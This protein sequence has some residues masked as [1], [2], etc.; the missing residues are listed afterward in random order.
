MKLIVGL[1]NP[2]AEYD[3][4]PHNVGFAVIDNIAKVAGAKFSRK[5][6]SQALWVQCKFAGVDVVL[7]KPQ[8]FMN[9][10]GDAVF[11]YADKYNI[12]PKDVLVI[13]DDFELSLGLIRGRLEG[14]G[15]THNGLKHIVMRLGTT[16]FARIR[17][18]VGMPE[19]NQDYAD[20]VL[21]KMTGK[22][23]EDVHLG[24]EKAEKLAEDF[25]NGKNIST[26]M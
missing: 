13:L 2:G 21:S 1:G 19:N 25:V 3:D 11:A 26:T 20:F 17:V 22:R 15:G 10:S 5:A 24:M 7:I 18:G 12:Q 16:S 4:T 9:N 8:T 14:T 23:L 6:K